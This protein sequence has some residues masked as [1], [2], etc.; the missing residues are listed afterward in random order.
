MGAV[1]RD[2]SIVPRVQIQGRTLHVFDAG[3][4]LDEAIASAIR[5]VEAALSGAARGV[6]IHLLGADGATCLVG[7]RGRTKAS[8]TGLAIHRRNALEQRQ[9]VWIELPDHLDPHRIA[10]FPLVRRGQAL[11]LLEVSAP[12]SVLEASW[13]RL[14]AVAEQSALLFA[15]V[16]GKKATEGEPR[17]DGGSFVLRLLHA[18]TPAGAV[19]EAVRICA[20]LLGLPVAGWVAQLGGAAMTFVAADG[21]EDATARRIAEAHG[22]LQRWARL[23]SKGRSLLLAELAGWMGVPM[24]DGVD[25]GEALLVIG[26]TPDEGTRRSIEL[27]RMVLGQTLRHRLTIEDARERRGR[28]DLAIA[29]TGHE[30]RGPLAGARMAI[31]RVLSADEGTREQRDVLRRTEREL[32]ELSMMVDGLLRWGVTGGAITQ[33]NVNLTSV[34]RK[35]VRAAVAERG[36]DRVRVHAPGR[37]TVRGDARHLR[38]AIV[39]LVRNALSYSPLGTEV[40]V[41]I[42]PLDDSVMVCVQDRGPGLPGDDL[43]SLF[44]PLVRGSAGRRSPGGRGLGLFIAKQVIDAHGGRIWAEDRRDGGAVFSLEIPSIDDGKAPCVR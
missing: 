19:E 33:R 3:S 9:A 35:A 44:E 6:S 10:F 15:S 18:E 16:T 2:R 20:E 22:S 41:T 13:A 34:V 30:I 37:V 25:A 5:S 36:E 7:A 31:E 38:S 28:L 39:N 24:L 26:R 40:D 14:G 32:R 1:L 43:A 12:T 29:R 27:I 21:I 4:D 23:G 42:R 17:H 8:V 11:G